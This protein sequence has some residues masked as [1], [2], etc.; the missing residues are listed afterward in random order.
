MRRVSLY[1]PGSVPCDPV[2][3]EFFRLWVSGKTLGAVLIGTDLQLLAPR[4]PPPISP[5]P[6]ECHKIEVEKH[7]TFVEF[8]TEQASS[9]DRAF[10][11]TPFCIH[12]KLDHKRA[13]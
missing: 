3:A 12:K 2:K 13:S 5:C 10:G 11:A 7:V 9:E 4:T 1:E 6:D 8:Q